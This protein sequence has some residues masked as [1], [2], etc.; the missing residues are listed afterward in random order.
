MILR[1]AELEKPRPKLEFSG[2]KGSPAKDPPGKIGPKERPMKDAMAT[3]AGARR[4]DSKKRERDR[5]LVMRSGILGFLGGE[6]RP[7]A[8]DSVLGSA[9]IG[10]GL[11]EALGGLSGLTTSDA[12]GVGGLASRGSYSGGGGPA[13]GLGGLGNRPGRRGTGGPGDVDLGGPGK[14]RTRLTPG[15]TTVTGALGREEIGRVIRAHLSRF[16]FCYERELSANRGLSGKISVHFT[17]APTG[18]VASAKVRESSM[19]HAVVESCVLRVM[20]SLQFPAPRGGGVVL[21]TYP[22][23]FQST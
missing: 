23:I 17:I 11:N 14:S 2:A 18:A 8:V 3:K 10:A 19:S 13:L 4:I 7:T 9:E 20:Q 6:G 21:V 22:F 1:P 16:K 5:D 15:T 12:G